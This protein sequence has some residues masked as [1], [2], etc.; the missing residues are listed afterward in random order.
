MRS[1]KRAD[2]NQLIEIMARLRDPDNGC[3][4]DVKQTMQS[5]TRY[6]IE[7]AYE[8]ADAIEKQRLEEVR[9]EL[10]DL[11]FQIVFY[12]QIAKEQGAFSFESVVDAICT[13]LIRRHPHVFEG[14]PIPES[15]LEAQWNKVKQA[16]KVCSQADDASLLDSVPAGLPALMFAQKIQKKCA[17]VGFDWDHPLDVLDKVQEE[18]SEISDELNA[19]NVDQAALEEEIGDTLFALVNLSR[20]CQIDA[21]T[22]LRRASNK[23]AARFK[24]VESLAQQGSKSLE[25]MSLEELESLWQQAKAT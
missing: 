13:K 3:P 11:L 19:P 24:I 15:E 1:E 22:A 16:E 9:D 12:A 17:S 5:L 7:E 21:D 18:V 10:G 23:F 8:V 4:W 2:I 25:A 14:K 6:T 20:H